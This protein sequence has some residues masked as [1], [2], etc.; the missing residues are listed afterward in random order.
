MPKSESVVQNE[1]RAFLG[2]HPDRVV[3]WRNNVGV[4]NHFDVKSGRIS[5]VVYGLAPG[6]SDLIGITCEGQFV[7]LELK[8]EKGGKEEDDQKMFIA[9]VQ[10]LGGR[11]GFVRSVA[12]AK[13]I[14]GW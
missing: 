14:L 6:S 11:A 7:A 5:K 2:A 12:D 10:K 4:A 1:V 8:R 3:L 9:L 13:R